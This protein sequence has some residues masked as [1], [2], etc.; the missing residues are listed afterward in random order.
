MRK[1]WTKPN[2]KQT[3]KQTNNLRGIDLSWRRE[4]GRI[5]IIKNCIRTCSVLKVMILRN[6]EVYLV[7]WK[8]SQRLLLKGAFYCMFLLYNKACQRNWRELKVMKKR[9]FKQEVLITHPMLLIQSRV[10]C[11]NKREEMRVV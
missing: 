8:L 6:A 2:Q 1:W 11:D 4:T 3:N 10:K 9:F 7:L 5:I